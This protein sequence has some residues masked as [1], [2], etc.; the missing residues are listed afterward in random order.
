MV[1]ELSS[2]DA[3]NSVTRG[4]VLNYY[5]SPHGAFGN[6]IHPYNCRHIQQM[7]V[8][9]RKVWADTVRELEAWVRSQGGS[10]DPTSP[11]C[12]YV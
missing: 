4:Y 3:L 11:T 6:T 5:S 1:Q 7:S 12:Q 8:P 10:L 2:I 9:P